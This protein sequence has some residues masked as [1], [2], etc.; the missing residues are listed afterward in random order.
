LKKRRYAPIG[1]RPFL[2]PLNNAFVHKTDT[3]R[4]NKPAQNFQKHPKWSA[5]EFMGKYE[6]ARAQVVKK[7]LVRPFLC[8][9]IDKTDKLIYYMLLLNFKNIKGGRNESR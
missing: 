1:K 8:V 7:G 2:F 5:F 6:N 3:D 9:T 4:R